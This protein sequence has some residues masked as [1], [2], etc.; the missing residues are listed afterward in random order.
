M[1]NF[2]FKRVFTAVKNNFKINKSIPL[3]I[4]IISA[5]TMF[6][7]TTMPVSSV[8]SSYVPDVVNYERHEWYLTDIKNIW[9]AICGINGIQTAAAA[10]LA[11]GAAFLTAVTLTSYSREKK[12]LDFWA[13]QSLTR[14]EHTAANIISS[15]IYFAVSIIPTWYISLALAHAFTTVPPESL[16]MVLLKQTPPLLFVLLFYIAILSIAY[17]AFTLAG[18]VMSGL[19][20]F[21]TLLGYPAL[22]VY[23]TAFVSDGVFDSYLF[24]I[25]RHDYT[26]FAYSSPILRYFMSF[27]ESLKLEVFDYVLF[28]LCSL[29]IFAIV[30]A[31]LPR[32]KNELA[33]N[34][35]VYPILRYPIQY[36]WTYFFTLFAAWFLYLINSSPIWFV[37]GA[38]IGLFVSFIVLNM[39][40]ERSFSSLFKSSKHLIISGA[41]FVAVA[42]VFVVD[43]FGIYKQ[44]EPD[45]DRI[46]SFSIH[47][48]S[49]EHDEFGEQHTWWD[50]HSERGHYKKL[51]QEDKESIEK[52]YKYLKEQAS[53]TNEK[54]VHISLNF[55][56]ERDPSRWY[57]YGY[58]S[59]VPPEIAKEIEELKLKFY[60]N[61]DAEYYSYEKQ[62]YSHVEP[63]VE[64]YEA[65]VD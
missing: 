40:F 11:I 52:L 37:L 4:F 33:Q 13:S 41:L 19:V 54:G 48:N 25:F 26:F 1:T 12:S 62:E 27:E 65:L 60:S 28:A 38:L 58:V 61:T 36:I 50:I 24:D 9:S 17:L 47:I 42:M 53:N 35:V 46:E 10:V 16:L 23:F 7:F 18:S 63:K 3:L 49:T 57:A 14:R 39:I 30:F 56:C 55:S 15:F 2:S 21:G 29:V 64:V 34:A 59:S 45:F 32:R 43:I 51:L 44:P 31:I 5:I 6:L 22:T 8:E 20:F